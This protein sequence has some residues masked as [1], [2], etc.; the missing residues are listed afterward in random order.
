V[1]NQACEKRLFVDAA[2]HAKAGLQGD[3][4]CFSYAHTVDH[5]QTMQI[6]PGS[7]SFT[8]CRFSSTS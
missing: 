5:F 4:P 1:A 3:L 7:A 8:R 6:P 2:G